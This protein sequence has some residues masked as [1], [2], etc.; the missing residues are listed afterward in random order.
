MFLT[1]PVRDFRFE[2]QASVFLALGFLMQR[3]WVGVFALAVLLANVGWAADEP[4]YLAQGL[5]EQARV[6]FY[7]KSQGS[8]LIPFPWFRAL[9]TQDGQPFADTA[10]LQQFGF[11][12]EPNVHEITLP[13][14]IGMAKDHDPETGAWLGLTCAACHTGEWHYQG[15]TVRVDGGA[16]RIDLVSFE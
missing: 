12:F 15:H 6:Y 8:Q 1:L 11:L 10:H 9:Q 4:L 5:T 16:G 13:L 3:Y 2:V 7:Q 14:P